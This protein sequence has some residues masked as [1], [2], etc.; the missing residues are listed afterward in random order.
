[1]LR[2]V[3]PKRRVS[4]Q[5]R[6]ERPVVAWMDKSWS[7]D[8]MSDELFDGRRNRLLTTIDNFTG[9][10]L[11]VK[12][13]ASVKGEAVVEVLQTLQQQHRLPRTIRRSYGPE[14]IP[15]RLDQAVY[16]ND[17]ELDFSRLGNPF[18]EAYNGRCRQEY[19]NENWLL[20]LEDAAEK[21]ESWRR[22]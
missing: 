6:M 14:F 5:R 13:A 2:T 20:S 8:F 1:M 16:L 21:V 11:A 15:K 7:M 19:L 4:C 9:E 18:I 10:S 3:K 17:V 12:V 22:H